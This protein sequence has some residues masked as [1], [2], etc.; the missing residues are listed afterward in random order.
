MDGMLEQQTPPAPVTLAAKV[1][2][3]SRAQDTWAS[4]PHGDDETQTATEARQVVLGDVDYP[5]AL[6]TIEAPP[7]H[8][9]V[10]GPLNQPGDDTAV[11]IVGS[12]DAS[13]NGTG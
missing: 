2:S 6:R 7:T 13:I 11:A 10:I 5:A 8:L 3:A 4:E 9:Y 12:R 1:T